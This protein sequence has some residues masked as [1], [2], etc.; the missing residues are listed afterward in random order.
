MR[1][2][3]AAT[4]VALAVVVAACDEARPREESTSA[5][6]ANCHGFPPAPPHPQDAAACNACHST[7]VGAG[8]A[9]VPGGTHA[10]GNVDVAVHPVRPYPTHA[11][12]AIAGISTCANCHGADYGGGAVSVS[13]NACHD[14]T[15]GTA[16]WRTNCTFCHG[17]RTAT[18]TDTPAQ[19]PLAAPPSA[20]D[21]T[22]SP[23]DPRV[24]AHQAHLAG[25][26][27]A[28]PL[29]C[30]A[31]HAVP[32]RTFPGSLSHLDGSPAELVF[33]ATA[34]KGVT[35]A[36]YA[37]GGGSC[38]VYCHGT[39]SEF[40]NPGAA[41]S[42]VVSPD[43]TEAAIACD[44]CHG[45]PPATG[46]H[47]FANHQFPCDRCHQ[48]VAGSGATPSIANKALHVNGTKNVA[49]TVPGT[50]TAEKTCADVSCH[51]GGTRPWYPAP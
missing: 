39:G 4:V 30:D 51:G 15:F 9:I 47:Q 31:C 41:A 48:G 43:W 33:G 13:C 16:D 21:G 35:G 6:C 7:S 5:A 50:W 23:A 29:A 19:F 42:A 28:N 20:V 38:A 2:V 10:N 27:Y 25:T 46:Q 34:T 36:G 3:R 18:W 26:A 45:T 17:T 22:T 44:G 32:A 40:V 14:S 11:Q 37:G 49:F 8:N 1:L 24:G 12:D